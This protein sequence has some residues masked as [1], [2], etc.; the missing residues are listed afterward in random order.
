MATE[1]FGTAS[2]GYYNFR[3]LN[4]SP[5][6]VGRKVS[7]STNR[8]IQS[9]GVRMTGYSTTTSTRS[10]HRGVLWNG[11]TDASVLSYSGLTTISSDGQGSTSTSSPFAWQDFDITNYYCPAG[12]YHIGFWRDSNQLTQWDVQN[13]SS[14]TSKTSG[15]SGAG[16]YPDT[17]DV[18]GSGTV[19]RGLVCRVTYTDV[20]VPSA[21]DFTLTPGN[22]S[23]ILEDID[24]IDNG[25]NGVS[26]SWSYSWE[27]RIK[28][29]SSST[30][31]AWT[32]FTPGGNALSGTGTYTISSRTAGTEYDVQ[33]RSRNGVGY[34]AAS[35]VYSEIPYGLP[36]MKYASLEY[37]VSTNRNIIEAAAFENFGDIDTWYFHRSVNGGAYTLY[38]T[39]TDDDEYDDIDNPDWSTITYIDTGLTLGNS[40]SYRV[41]A[42]NEA[43]TS[44]Y[45]QTNVAVAITAPSKPLNLIATDVGPNYIDISWSA[46]ADNG[47]DSIDS[48]TI[49][50]ETSP[51]V[52]VPDQEYE[53]TIDKIVVDSEPDGEGTLYLHVSTS[54]LTAILTENTDFT[55]IDLTNEFNLSTAIDTVFTGNSI[56]FI[57]DSLQT[58][59]YNTDLNQGMTGLANRFLEVSYSDIYDTTLL[60]P[61]DNEDYNYDYSLVPYSISEGKLV[62]EVF[63]SDYNYFNTADEI[64][65]SGIGG[66]P[67][68]TKLMFYISGSAGVP[69]SYAISDTV[70][71]SVTSYSITEGYDES[72]D[73]TILIE[74]NTTYTIGVF[75]T[76]SAGDGQPAELIITTIGGRI[77]VYSDVSSEWLYGETKVFRNGAWKEVLIKKYNGTSW[78]YI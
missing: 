75:A 24:I 55:E 71:P 50:I 70:L 72:Q 2:G 51:Q 74:P 20:S 36:S 7:F 37:E 35:D 46:P 33:I 6:N 32:A 45:A 34:S 40:Y 43:G 17:L 73:L 54:Q 28:A 63:A 4:A 22:S 49:F 61:Y 76:N 16:D 52:P 10:R 56:K 8:V 39:V 44:A 62:L 31:G 42:K 9:V 53:L 15:A 1:T 13:S 41:S 21:P 58:N 26:I 60:E 59:I 69:A 67:S 38:A 11:A 47:G 77:K 48:Y 66:Y 78:E 57:N 30:W 12:T 29:S 27:Y 19:H 18:S 5:Y 14:N 23:L 64:I 3:A 65:N 25:T 68:G